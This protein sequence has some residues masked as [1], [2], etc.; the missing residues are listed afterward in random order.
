MSNIDIE[1]AMKAAEECIDARNAQKEE[2]EE[3]PVNVEEPAVETVEDSS[4]LDALKE[5]LAQKEDTIAAL[6]NEVLL[7]QANLENF[8]KR[9]EKELNECRKYA[10]SKVL[11][12]FLPVMDNCKRAMEHLPASDD[13]TYK[14]ITTGLKMIQDGFMSTLN[15]YG[16]TLIDSLGCTF[17]PN[18]HEALTQMPT[19]EYQP[20]QICQVYEDGYM[21]HDRLLRAA[22]VVVACALPDSTPAAEAAAD[23]TESKETN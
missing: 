9:S 8:R 3:I 4:E 14:N 7:A 17:D 1:E 15:R 23:Q 22:K 16:V 19:N 2:A 11:T 13:D 18:V 20:G 6:K 10:A 12:D 21:I 5:E